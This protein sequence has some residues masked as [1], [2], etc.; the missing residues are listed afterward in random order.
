MNA[1]KNLRQDDDLTF[2][3]P[4]D[5]TPQRLWRALTDASIV[6]RWLAPVVDSGTDPSN[7]VDGLSCELIATEADRSASY[8]WRDPE[9]GASMVTFSISQRSD[10][11]SRLSIVHSGLPL[12]F[13]IAAAGETV[14]RARVGGTA[15]PRQ[16]A[17]GNRPLSD[18]P[19]LLLAA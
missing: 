7:S 12:A 16:A 11:F 4:I 14:C 1:D 19:P 3:V 18:F 10:G 5:E 13:T 2:D 17:N 8:I 9:A 15:A 6:E